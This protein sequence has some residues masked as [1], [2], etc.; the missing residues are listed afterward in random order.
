M[1]TTTTLPVWRLAWRV[2]QHEPRSFWLGWAAFVVFFSLP[3]LNG[4]VLSQGFEAIAQD[5]T[6]SVLR[7]AAL[8]A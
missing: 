3:A 8:F 2:S 6:A 7:W 1:S 4:F 5:D